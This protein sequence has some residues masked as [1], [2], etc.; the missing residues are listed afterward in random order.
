MPVLMQMVPA[1]SFEQ[2]LYKYRMN[3]EKDYLRF[4]RQLIEFSNKM[5]YEAR[6]GA[7]DHMDVD[8]FAKESKEPVGDEYYSVDQWDAY[9]DQCEQRVSELN[10]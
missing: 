1:K 3:P 6:R 8:T 4:S 2:V 10:V 7:G 5:W 9:K